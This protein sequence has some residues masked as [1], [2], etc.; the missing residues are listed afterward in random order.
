MSGLYEDPLAPRRG[1]IFLHPGFRYGF[2]GAVVA[3]FINLALFLMFAGDE[4]GDRLAWA[5]Q[6]SVYVFVSRAAAENQY[7]R[8]IREGG[9]EHLRGVQ[10]AGLGAGLVTSTLVWL[11][12][13]IRGIIRDEFFVEPVSMCFFI[14][15]DVLIAMGLG[16]WSGKSV[17]NKY[18]IDQFE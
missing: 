17:S 13:V 2:I 3:I 5:L 1:N 6:L 7:N 14:F 9:M 12:L 10:A 11:Y 8:N 15:I 16:A 4:T 18:R